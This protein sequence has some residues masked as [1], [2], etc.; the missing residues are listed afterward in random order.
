MKTLTLNQTKRLIALVAAIASLTACGEST[1]SRSDGGGTSTTTGGT[2]SGTAIAQCNVFDSNTSDRIAGR[3]TTYFFNGAQQ[4]DKTRLRISTLPALFDGNSG[5]TIKFFR[6]NASATGATNLDAT[7][8]S[9]TIEKGTTDTQ[10]ISNAMTSISKADVDSLR[11]SGSVSGTTSQ[12]FFNNTI[13]V[14]SG[15]DYTWDTLKV[16]VY[17]GTSVLASTDM[18]LPAIAANPNKYATNHPAVLNALHPFYSQRTDN[19]TDADWQ[20]R[21]NTLCF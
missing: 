7:P 9:F 3:A 4:E 15:T 21:A 20:T 16:V 8:L 1:K 5:V 11:S 17:N 10:S 12:Q 18:L 2:T 14:I 19:I 13:F 6:W